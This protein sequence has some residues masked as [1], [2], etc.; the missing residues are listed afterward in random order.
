MDF[1]SCDKSKSVKD[2][3]F[4]FEIN[5]H[6]SFINIVAIKKTWAICHLIIMAIHVVNT[7][8]KNFRNASYTET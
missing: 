4:K 5:S 8:F 2:F 1:L 6:S 7:Q 3:D